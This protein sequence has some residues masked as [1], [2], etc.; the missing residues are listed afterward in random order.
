ML[1]HELYTFLKSQTVIFTALGDRI[2]PVILPA[3]TLLPAGSQV[4]DPA[5]ARPAMVW[6]CIRRPGDNL[7]LAGE[8]WNSVTVE[9]T[10]WG[11]TYSD[12][13]APA[14]AVLTTL[15]ELAKQDG[16]TIGSLCV[17]AIALQQEEDVFDEDVLVYGRQL[18]FEFVGVGL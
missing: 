3:G 17:V 1:H 6:R 14:M 7:D 18:T 13:D 9:M 2:Y 10:V 8:S 16:I 5:Q 12:I 15:V 4:K 11:Q